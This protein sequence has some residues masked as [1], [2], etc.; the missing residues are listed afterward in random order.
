MAGNIKGITIEY[1]AVTTPLEQALNKIKA[2]SASVE[3]TLSQINK[4]LHFDPHNTELLAQ[5]QEYLKQRIDGAKQGL[6]EFHDAENQL[7]AQK[8]DETSEAFKKVR[9]GIIESESKIR[10]FNAQ[11]ARMKWEGVRNVGSAV[12][13][14]GQRLQHATR[15]ARMFVGALTGLALYKGF[16][17]LK[18]LDETAKSLEVLGYRGEKLNKIMDNVSTSVDG[19]RFM[20]QDMAKVANGAL[21]SGVTE[22]Y[23]LDEYLTR[24][25]D[26]AQLS[27]MS[28]TE[29]GAMM[30]KAYSKGKVQAQLMNQFNQRGIPI[31]KL[32]QKELGVSADKL[33]EM[34][35]AGLITFDDLYKATN[36]YQGLAQK[37]GTETLPGALEVLKAQFGLVGAD[38]LSGVYEPL[39]SGVKGIVK[40]IK[41]LRKEGTFKEWGQDLG[42][43]VKY[44]IDYFKEGEASMDGMSERAQNLVSVLS[45]LIKTIGQ[46]VGMLA[47][48]P[49]ELQGV[50]GLFALFGGPMLNGLGSAIIGVSTLGMNI[51]TMC[52]NAQAG[53]LQMGGFTSGATLMGEAVGALVNP[54]TLA[55]GVVLAWALGV[56][57][58]YDEEHQFTQSLDKFMEKAD[59][60]IGAVEASGA[61]LDVYKNQLD[62]LM[63]KEEKSAADKELIKTYVDKLNGAIDGLNLK[64]NEEEDKLNK[65]SKAIEKK[66][67]K[68][69]ELALA[70]AYEDKLAEAAKKHAEMQMELAELYEKRTQLEQEWKES[71][72]HGWAATQGYNAKMGEL[73]RKIEDG[74]KAMKDSENI[75]ND[76]ADMAQ[77]AGKKTEE[78]GDKTK[79]GMKK[80]GE[81][82]PKELSNGIKKN[83][84]LVKKASDELADAAKSNINGLPNSY[85]NVGYDMG[86]GMKQGIMNSIRGVASAG[87]KMAA[88]AVK[89]ARKAAEESSPSRAT[90]RI[91]RFFG[92]G[93]AMGIDDTGS[94]VMNASSHMVNDA[95]QAATVPAHTVVASGSQSNTTNNS[96]N[97]TNYITVNG[98]ED[99]SDWA[100]KFAHQ[101][102]LQMRL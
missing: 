57:K 20:L 26:L 101:L 65:T 102:E 63:G 41:T 3:G 62:E 89:A 51:Q 69:K 21:G 44:F 54:F 16:E 67:S 30:N 92:L 100:N 33:Q 95:L 28:V 94:V 68:Y 29:M 86:A 88:D 85:K 71:A 81:D 82:A 4:Q 43:A 49:P 55:T 72:D 56:K 47:K 53:V 5:K 14:A 40:W 1:D 36:R 6:K 12:K 46:V 37:M 52:M 76:W 60:Q 97:V 19:T 75:M 42:D 61:E 39:K 80:A 27:G 38:F 91:G 45:P 99:P 73:N 59:E 83:K 74:E 50:V 78:A 96:N 8:V 10:T 2:K 17:R 70:K 84:K 13:T 7:R 24:T 58:A 31:Y 11:L 87:A 23:S 48:L 25:A 34:S 79:K 77:K 66:I 22:K 18:S 35:K 98:A 64:Y 9:R 15:Y 93:F 90:R 32:L